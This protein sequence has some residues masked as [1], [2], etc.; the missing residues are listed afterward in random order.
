M[1]VLI[2]NGDCL[3]A[4]N[5][6]RA[7]TNCDGIEVHVAA[8]KLTSPCFLSRYCK[9]KLLNVPPKED[10]DL[11][12]RQLVDYVR[13]QKI[14]VLLPINPIEVGLVLHARDQFDDYVIIPFVSHELFQ[15]MNDKWNFFSLMRALDIPTPD[16]EKVSGFLDLA[17]SA[18]PFPKVLKPISGAGSQGVRIV[19][20]MPE[21][22]RAYEGLASSRWTRGGSMLLQAHVPGI[23]YGAGAVCV[24][25]KVK[26]TFVYRSLREDKVTH[27][28][29]SSRMSVRDKVI[30]AQVARILEEL[31]WHG[32]AH[33]DII[34]SDSNYFLEMNPRIWLSISLPVSCG[35]NYPYYLC[36]LDNLP[37]IPAEYRLNVIQRVIMADI[38]VFIRSIRSARRYTFRDFLRRSSFDDFDPKDIWP[39]LYYL[40][41]ALTGGYIE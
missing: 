14:S 31:E 36:R 17:E 38:A 26:S 19:R 11:F 35:L 16:T 40:R 13:K 4:Y 28:T 25:G 29:S 20:N 27:G 3:K 15:A 2:T 33:F 12:I 18:I 23:L 39:S 5:V 30:E 37:E 41:K 10:E 6:L 1:K 8:E 34:K 32:V 24:R 7:L 21:L 22:V 9:G